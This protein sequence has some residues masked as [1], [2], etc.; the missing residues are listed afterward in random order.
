MDITRRLFF[1]RAAALASTVYAA[2]GFR[3]YPFSLGGM[4]GD[5]SPDGFV[6]WTRLAPEPLN[7]GGMDA[8]GLEV[9]WSVVEDEGMR[10]VVKR[11]AAVAAAPLANSVHVEVRCM[12]S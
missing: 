12:R 9:Q 5:P 6:L 4:S 8:A 10:R 3:K 2:P 7:G 1:I 11:A